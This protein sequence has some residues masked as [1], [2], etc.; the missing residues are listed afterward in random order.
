MKVVGVTSVFVRI[1]VFSSNALVIC[2]LFIDFSSY[3]SFSSP[4]RFWQPVEDQRPAC[5]H[6]QP[7]RRPAQ[8]IGKGTKR[9]GCRF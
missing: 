3:F 9:C 8:A 6:G 5:G 4:S 1:R 2:T 7:S